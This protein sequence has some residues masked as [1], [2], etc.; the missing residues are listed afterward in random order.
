LQG[1]VFVLEET[2]TIQNGF[3]SVVPKAYKQR[4]CRKEKTRRATH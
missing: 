4:N 2:R 3:K 1:V